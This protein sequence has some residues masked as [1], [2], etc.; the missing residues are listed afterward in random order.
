M[1]SK[2]KQNF[3]EEVIDNFANQK[4]EELSWWIYNHNSNVLE[5]YNNIHIHFHQSVC[6]VFS[7]KIN[8][9]IIS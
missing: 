8:R 9:F 7:K 2:N 1:S 3:N 6:Y 5:I 4:I